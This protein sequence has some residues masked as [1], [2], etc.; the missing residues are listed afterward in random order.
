VIV[1]LARAGRGALPPRD[2][3]VERLCAA[4][5]TFPLMASRLRSHHWVPAGPPA[6]HV[7]EDDPIAAAPLSHFDLVSEP[8]LR[9]MTSSDADW[10]LLC[11]HHFAFDGLGMVALLDSLLTGRSTAA[12]DYG[13]RTSPRRPPTD[14]LRRIVRPADPVARSP[15]RPSTESLVAA[16]VQLSGPQVTAQIAHACTLAVRAH[17]A[18][19]GRPLRRI[20][21]SIAVGGIGGE[22]ATYRRLDLDPGEDVMT[23]VTGAMAQQAMPTELKGLPPGAFLLRPA[24]HRLSDTVLVSNLGRLDLPLVSNVEFYPVARGRSAVAIGASGLP[25]RPTTVTLRARDLAQLDASALLEDMVTRLGGR[26]PVGGPGAHREGNTP[27]RT[28]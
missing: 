12:S 22:G 9:V 26:P 20:G 5:R 24:L 19:R 18:E 16:E 21:L 28:G 1:L 6:V 8:P 23:A 14:A 27:S 4:S 15:I 25:G 17:N 7:T 10:V 2:V 11:G 3:L 13:M